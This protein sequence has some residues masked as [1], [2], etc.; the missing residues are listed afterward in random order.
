MARVAAATAAPAAAAAALTEFTK[1]VM[2][3]DHAQRL[4]ETLGQHW[5][6]RINCSALAAHA[7]VVISQGSLTLFFPAASS[8]SSAAA[9]AAAAA[10]D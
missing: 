6:L 1:V 4:V 7:M 10:A 3:K 2:C 9:A 8:S 5:K